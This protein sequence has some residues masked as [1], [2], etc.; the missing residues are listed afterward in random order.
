MFATEDKKFYSS[1]IFPT[2]PGKGG[3]CWKKFGAKRKQVFI[4]ITNAGTVFS[5]LIPQYAKNVSILASI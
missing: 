2:K 1:K 3:Q 5:K 4:Q